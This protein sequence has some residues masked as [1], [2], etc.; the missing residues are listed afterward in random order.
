MIVTR[1]NL[2][3]ADGKF[4][5]VTFEGKHDNPFD[6]I[7]GTEYSDYRVVGHDIID[8]GL[9]KFNSRPRITIGKKNCINNTILFIDR[10]LPQITNKLANAF[11]NQDYE[12]MRFLMNRLT[13]IVKDLDDMVHELDNI[14][15][16][17]K[18]NSDKTEV[19]IEPTTFDISVRFTDIQAKNPLE[20]AKEIAK[21]L[22]EDANTL[23]YDVVNE[24]TKEAFTVDLSCE[25]EDAVLPNKVK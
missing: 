21:W 14:K 23:V 10:T 16:S 5:V 4:K 3:H 20:A 2:L 12:A 22:L 8:L 15:K 9:T 7:G 25:D 13:A 24:Q 6:F 1:F 17:G 19:S 18:H 11:S